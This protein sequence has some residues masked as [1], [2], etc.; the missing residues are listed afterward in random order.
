[1]KRIFFLIALTLMLAGFG[2]AQISVPVKKGATLPA[3]CTP[4]DTQSLL[5]YKTGASN[6]LYICSAID[7]WTKLATGSFTAGPGSST[8]NAIV[9]FD[10][11]SGGILQN[12]P[13][14]V[15]D[16]TGAIAGTQSIALSGSTSG[17]LTIN[18]AATAG[19]NIL[20]L[21]AGTTNFTATGGTS[22][23]LQQ[24]TAGGAI[25]VGQLAASNLS[26]G[27]TGSGS[28]VLAT[29]PTLVTPALGTPSAA[30]LTN[31]SGL[32]LTTGVTGTLPV[33][34]GGTGV[35]T[36]TGSG[37][38]VLSNSPTL[39]TPTL[40]TPTSLTLT[41]ATGLP[42][43]TG[44]SG[45]GTGVATALG[46]PSSANLATAITDETGSGS[47]V[48]ATSPT[49]VTPNLGT[50]SAVVLTNATGTAASLTAG[51]AT[52]LAANPTDCSANNYATTIAANGNLTCSQVSL[53]AG[54]TGTLPVGNGGT[55]VTSSTGS[56]NLVLSTSP[57]LTTPNLGTPSAA[58]LTNA[59]GLPLTTGVTGTLPVAN[60]GT[61][62]GSAS[63]ARTNLGINSGT[64]PVLLSSTSSVN[65]NSVANTTLYTVPANRKLIITEIVIREISAT[66]GG[67]G[68][69]SI[70][71][72]ASAYDNVAYWPMVQSLL[73]G[74]TALH[75]SRY[76]P[77]IGNTPML[78]PV[79]VGASSQA[80]VLRVSTANGSA[81]TVTVDVFGYLTDNSGVIQSNI[82]VP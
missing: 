40:G 19:T 34:N 39:V 6:G 75:M 31:A 28:V 54:V 7:T 29:S 60:G 25:T 4:T 27:T 76:E 80:L 30:V 46:T 13:V 18:T 12:S 73:V 74:A 26:N 57:T 72:N 68:I 32:P 41:N 35:T 38:N 5:F 33:A 56:G 70:G 22:Q 53:T 66:S 14:T 47:L 44:V 52:A 81:L 20:T 50:P 55:G 71:F 23:V 59:T 62:S 51:A 69:F 63:G 67:T 61:G 15:A 43:S 2:S 42:V 3:T 78:T 11:T 9:R 64:A 49:L 17:S 79:P 58:T 45:L 65:L 10:G 1:M 48:F 36:S 21:P 37:S 77:N 8:D 82:Y 16:T 24:T